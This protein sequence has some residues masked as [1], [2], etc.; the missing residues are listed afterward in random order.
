MER[1]THLP[2]VPRPGMAGA[3]FEP[4][5]SL[6]CQLP[7]FTGKLRAGVGPGGS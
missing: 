6:P 5:F 4:M 3:G 7:L 2:K 1:M